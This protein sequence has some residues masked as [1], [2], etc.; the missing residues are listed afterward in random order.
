LRFQDIELFTPMSPAGN[1]ERAVFAGGIHFDQTAGIN[2]AHLS[3]DSA[4][5]PSITVEFRLQGGLPRLYFG[6]DEAPTSVPRAFTLYHRGP[7]ERAFI[8]RHPDWFRQF[9]H[10][11]ICAGSVFPCEKWP[12]TFLSNSTEDPSG[13]HHGGTS[14][15][16]TTCRP[17]RQGLQEMCLVLEIDEYYFPLPSPSPWQSP[18]PWPTQS[19][20]PSPHASAADNQGEFTENSGVGKGVGIG[21]A[22]GVVLIGVAGFVA[23]KIFGTSSSRRDYQ[24]AD[25]P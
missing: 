16:R 21:L 15:L 14:V 22:V 1:I 9:S 13:D 11:I 6:T 25:L 7:S 2:V 5:L 12:V 4:N 17:Q 18:P 10:E 19:H 20:P 3:F 23:Y 8:A 24:V